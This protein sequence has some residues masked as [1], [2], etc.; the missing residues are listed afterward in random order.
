MGTA[1]T[2]CSCIFDLNTTDAPGSCQNNVRLFLGYKGHI[3][4]FL[5]V[6]FLPVGT[7]HL[8]ILPLALSRIVKVT[9]L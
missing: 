4:L 8:F 2:I 7:L 6:F 9:V 3:T 1:I 5:P